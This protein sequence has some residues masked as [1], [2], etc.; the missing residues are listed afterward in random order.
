[1]YRCQMKNISFFIS[2]GIL[3]ALLYNK[4]PH[5]YAKLNI[6]YTRRST[7]N[8]IKKRWYYF[9]R[10]QYATCK[11]ILSCCFEKFIR[12]QNLRFRTNKYLILSIEMY[13]FYTF[14][15]R[16]HP[17]YS[18]SHKGYIIANQLFCDKPLS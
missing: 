17:E 12:I 15:D 13:M 9:P 3:L 7:S 14:L 8:N 6:C 4:K 11:Y 1:M 10:Y 18:N 2:S 16:I 5:K